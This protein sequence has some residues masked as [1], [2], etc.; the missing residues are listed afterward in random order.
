M[1]TFA[2]FIAESFDSEVQVNWKLKSRVQVVATFTVKSILVQV[3]FEQREHNGPWHVSFNTLHG[4]LTDLK[5]EMLAIR[6]LNGVFQAVHE[7]MEAREPEALA[8]IAKDDDR[9]SIYSAYLHRERPKI[10]SLGYKLEGP[11]RI[12]PYTEWTLWRMKASGLRE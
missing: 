7:F 4:E 10:E 5:N 6:R 1:Q 2:D 9:A 3:D 8:F 11:H 12:E